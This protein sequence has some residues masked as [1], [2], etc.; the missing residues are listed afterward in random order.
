[1]IG[2]RTLAVVALLAVAAFAIAS[3]ALGAGY[4]DSA[5]FGVFPF[6]N[7][8][9]ALALSALAGVALLAPHTASTRRFASVIFAAALAWLPISVWLAGNVALN[10]SGNRGTVW[11]AFTTGVALLVLASLLFAFALRFKARHHSGAT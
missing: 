10:F 1:M 6:G 8:L 7:I 11:L 3:L 2:K 9:A 5:I 4:L